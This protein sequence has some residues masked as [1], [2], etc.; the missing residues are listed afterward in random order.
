M[1]IRAKIFGDDDEP[2]LVGEKKP[3]GAKAKELRS[4]VVPR[5]DRHRSNSRYEDRHR[6]MNEQVRLTHKGRRRK[7]EL[8]N[9]SGGGAM[10]SGDFKPKLWDRVELHLGENGTIE[11]A[12]C[13]VRED[14]IGLEFAHETRLDCSPNEQ[15]NVL[16][17][18]IARS[19][20]DIRFEQPPSPDSEPASEEQRH[21][22]RHPLIWSGLLHHGPAKTRVRV[23]NISS[24][25]EMIESNE[26]VLVGG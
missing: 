12:V 2:V 3:R 15:T 19:F 14:R 7:V 8:I 26:P 4:V 18:V 9:L 17:E 20:P 21:E 11:C 5:E 22:G 16:R 25:G 1:N 23:R 24:T 6:L 10:V 13:W